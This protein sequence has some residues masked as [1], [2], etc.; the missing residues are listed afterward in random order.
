MTVYLIDS[1]RKR[2]S[3]RGTGKQVKKVARIDAEAAHCD[4]ESRLL[5][6]SRLCR[7]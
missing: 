7:Q 5:S 1:A 2:N 3:F 6:V 4:G